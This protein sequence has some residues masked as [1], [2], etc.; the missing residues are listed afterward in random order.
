MLPQEQQENN[1]PPL[2]AYKLKESQNSWG[3]KGPLEITLYNL[4]L[5]QIHLEQVPQDCGFESLQRMRLHNLSGQPIPLLCLSHSKV[6]PHIQME[7]PVFQSVPV[8]PCPVTGQ[9]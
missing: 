8:D 6:L 5:K 9:H 1:C 3:C 7:F 4:L 2:S